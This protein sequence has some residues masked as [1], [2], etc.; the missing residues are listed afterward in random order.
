MR[1]LCVQVSQDY[2]YILDELEPVDD[3]FMY[4]EYGYN[5]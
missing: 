2:C 3:A 4:M 5:D 1:D